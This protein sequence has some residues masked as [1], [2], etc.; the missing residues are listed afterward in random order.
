[1]RGKRF[2]LASMVAW[3]AWCWQA[4]A[5]GGELSEALAAYKNTP[6]TVVFRLTPNERMSGCLTEVGAD[7]LVLSVP[8]TDAPGI[9]RPVLIPFQAFLFVTPFTQQTMRCS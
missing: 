2:L 4:P 3:S 1:M 9:V 8:Q 6:V 5:R 7:Y